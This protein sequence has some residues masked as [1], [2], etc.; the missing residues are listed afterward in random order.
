MWDR[1][2]FFALA[3]IRVQKNFLMKILVN[4][5]RINVKTGDHNGMTPLKWIL[6]NHK[7]WRLR[8]L[9]CAQ[10]TFGQEEIDQAGDEP[11]FLEAEILIS[12]YADREKAQIE[13]KQELDFSTQTGTKIIQTKQ[14]KKKILAVFKLEATLKDERVDINQPKKSKRKASLYCFHHSKS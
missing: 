13:L 3:N 10:D 4:H 11:N 9:L 12:Y 6:Q 1:I 7:L 14:G 8:I 5:Q 2:L